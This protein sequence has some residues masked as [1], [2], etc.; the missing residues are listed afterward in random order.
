MGQL[1]DRG[2]RRH[3]IVGNYAQLRQLGK[4]IQI[5]FSRAVTALVLNSVVKG[6]RHKHFLMNNGK[7]MLK[8]LPK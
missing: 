5:N 6:T 2:Q 1:G 3:T 4:K 7:G 8:K